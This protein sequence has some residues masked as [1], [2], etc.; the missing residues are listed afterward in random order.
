MSELDLNL[1]WLV[2]CFLSGFFGVV[3]LIIKM[4]VFYHNCYEAKVFVTILS[5]LPVIS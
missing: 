4:V 3:F 5:L 2:G 1:F